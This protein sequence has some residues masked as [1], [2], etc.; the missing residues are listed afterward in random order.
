MTKAEIRRV[1]FFLYS[2]SA[3]AARVSMQQL[4]W[5]RGKCFENKEREKHGETHFSTAAAAAGQRRRKS[6]L[7]FALY[8][9]LFS[10]QS[11]N[12][13]GCA[14]LP[15]KGINV[16]FLQKLTPFATNVSFHSPSP[17][18]TITLRVP[19]TIF[20]NVFFPF[21]PLFFFS[22]Q[23]LVNNIIHSPPVFFF[24]WQ[25][26][27]VVSCC[28]FP[29]LPFLLLLLLDHSFVSSSS[30]L[31]P[32]ELTENRSPGLLL[33]LQLHSLVLGFTSS[34]AFTAGASQA[35]YYFA[36]LLSFTFFFLLL[37]SFPFP[38]FRPLFR[39]QLQLTISVPREPSK[40]EEEGLPLYICSSSS[41]P[42]SYS[43]ERT[44]AVFFFYG[45]KQE[46]FHV[47]PSSA[48]LSVSRAVCRAV[49]VRLVLVRS[50][51]RERGRVR[52]E[53]IKA[54]LSY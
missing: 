46:G 27:L 47:F 5:E 18:I 9:R 4:S 3:A 49:Q 2:F 16:V 54:R 8:L 23:T 51:K 22:P 32:C 48:L 14:S 17:L 50:I 44:L 38:L 30:S 34:L 45:T 39:T 10:T 40:T 19:P 7:L 29:S 11:P 53:K 1:P 25:R 15:V 31:F 37:S 13:I 24:L 35:R 33:L 41:L 12:G 43:T 26:Q 28:F 52:K 42:P 20:S 21:P 6:F 36:L